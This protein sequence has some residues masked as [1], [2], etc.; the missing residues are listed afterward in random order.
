M[1]IVRVREKETDY[2]TRSI[3]PH[4]KCHYDVQHMSHWQDE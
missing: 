1:N 2:E 4:G 3:A